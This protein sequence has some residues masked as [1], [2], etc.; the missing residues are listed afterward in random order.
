MPI[1]DEQLNRLRR[2]EDPPS[3]VVEELSKASLDSTETLTIFDRPRRHEPRHRVGDLPLD[4]A[5]AATLAA[6]RG[7]KTHLRDGCDVEAVS[8]S[9]LERA[10]ASLAEDHLIIPQREE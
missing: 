4:R 2:Y 1:D 10:A 3:G 5:G 6:P 9:R 8:H 7:E